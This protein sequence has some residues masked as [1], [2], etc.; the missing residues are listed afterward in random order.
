MLI[1]CII[2]Y[3]S[4]KGVL[5]TSYS[6]ISSLN[7]YLLTNYSSDIRPVKNQSDLTVVDMYVILR[8]VRDFQDLDGIL[9]TSLYLHMSWIDELMTWEPSEFN[10][11]TQTKIP[12]T[13]VWYPSFVLTNPSESYTFLDESIRQV[14]VE[15]TF[16]GRASLAMGVFIKSSCE[17]TV[18]YYPSDTHTCD[19][20]ITT[21]G[22][23]E[24]EI[25]FT[26]NH[27]SFHMNGFQESSLWDVHSCNIS[28]YTDKSKPMV[29]MTLSLTRR[30]MFLLVNLLLPVT[31]LLILN[32][33][34]FAIPPQSGEKISY[35]ITNVLS[36]LVFITI[37]MDKIPPVATEVPVTSIALAMQVA[38]SALICIVSI[39]SVNFYHK[40]DAECI[41]NY[42]KMLVKFSKCKC[43]SPEK[44]H[45]HSLQ[46][47]VTGNSNI[48]KHN[49]DTCNTCNDITWEMVSKS[50]N[51]MGFAVN[52]IL[53]FVQ[54]VLILI[55]SNGRIYY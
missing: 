30:P 36:L 1:N 13:K 9:T 50:V 38:N 8:L 20:I 12:M 11:V 6:D 40:S 54:L 53:V 24:K 35:S 28:Y 34:T 17:L 49:A 26:K 22:Y 23:N 15:Y 5:S 10:N 19:I 51:R 21:P 43:C 42:L 44:T 7:A 45:D 47:T 31:F 4:I 55:L 2:T 39:Y 16:E 14:A 41:P 18:K 48:L 32:M 52:I 33:F 46:Q 25:I 29:K 27:E 3:C 37:L